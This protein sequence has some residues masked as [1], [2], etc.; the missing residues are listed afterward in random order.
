MNLEPETT[1]GDK[2]KY[3][4]NIPSSA[5]A[6]KILNGMACL[7]RDQ[8]RYGLAEQLFDRVLK[9]CRESESFYGGILNSYGDKPLNAAQVIVNIGDL[10]NR[11]GEG[12]Q[13]EA[14]YKEALEEARSKDG[15][16]SPSLRPILKKLSQFY[17]SEGRLSEAAEMDSQASSLREH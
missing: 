17:R 16:D 8:G 7:Y 12:R 10:Y 5:D 9:M 2:L 3:P 4:D 13:A 11:E 6:A 15:D 1:I 14:K